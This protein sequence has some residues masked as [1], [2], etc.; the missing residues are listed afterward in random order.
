MYTLAV[1]KNDAENIF[2]I[3]T[4]VQTDWRKNVNVPNLYSKA[5]TALSG[6]DTA[7]GSASSSLFRV[8]SC[9]KQNDWDVDYVELGDVSKDESKAQAE[10]YAKLLEDE[11]YTCISRHPRFRAQTGEYAGSKWRATK[12]QNLRYAQVKNH[13]V[14]MLQDCFYKGEVD[15]TANRISN[16]A[17]KVDSEILNIS[18]MWQ[19]VYNEYAL[20]G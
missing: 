20:K 6:K 3:W 14:N 1:F 12:I 18:Q 4:T 16:F 9:T 15:L 17:L 8:A 19:H 5:R 11:G 13:A 7:Q 10:I 2:H